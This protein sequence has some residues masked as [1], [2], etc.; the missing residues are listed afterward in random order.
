MRRGIGGRDE[1]CAPEE[2]VLIGE[3]GGRVEERAAAFIEEG[4]TK[5]VVALEAAGVWVAR[6]GYAPEEVPGLVKER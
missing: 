1:E 3:I 5:P 6:M 4:M 2:V